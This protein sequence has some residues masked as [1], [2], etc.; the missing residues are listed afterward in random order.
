MTEA[1]APAVVELRRADIGYEGRPVVAGLDL[2]IDAGE[3]IGLLGPNGSGKSTLVR[4]LL[5]LAP[6][7]G[8]SV[9]LFGVD[10]HRFKDWARVGYVPQRQT[11]VGGIPSTVREVVASGQLTSVRP[12]RRP[13]AAERAAVVDAIEAVGLADKAKA[14]MATLSGGQQRRVLI[15]RALASA[16]DLLVLDE[17]T[18]GVDSANQVALAATLAGL[19]ERGTTILLIT[20]ELG[21]AEPLVTRT[22]VLRAGRLVHDG[23]ASEAPDEHD[24]DWHHHHGDHPDPGPALGLEG[25]CT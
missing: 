10:R 2:R 12:F 11:V 5:G 14:A 4:G 3:V 6:I 17:P 22:L 9:S 18:A 8:G 25:P 1:A 19:A 7:L 24:D 20:H 23:P 15:A 21:P 13:R 16:P